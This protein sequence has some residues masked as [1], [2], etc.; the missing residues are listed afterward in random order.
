MPYWDSYASQWTDYP[1]TGSSYQVWANW[2]TSATTTTWDNTT[3]GGLVN[4]TWVAWTTTVVNTVATVWDAWV[5]GADG[6]MYTQPAPE[7]EEQ[8]RERERALGEWR[9]ER[10]AAKQ[11]ARDLLAAHLDDEQREALERRAAFRVIASDGEEY[12]IEA[13]G[14]SG[15]VR[16]IVGG[17]TVERLCV[18]AFVDGMPDEDHWLEQKLLLEADVETFR[19]TAN[20]TRVA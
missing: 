7:T 20:I 1:A 3:G 2:T 15:N 6:T 4:G 16:R 12:E 5:V 9:A 14:H 17:R 19:R 18:H 10:E 11:R 13:R 8:R